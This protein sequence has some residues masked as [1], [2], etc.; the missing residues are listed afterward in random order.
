MAQ[1]SSH[2]DPSSSSGLVLVQIVS[3]SHTRERLDQGF[4]CIH[5][6]VST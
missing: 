2:K 6:F 1:P 5:E 4:P 3:M